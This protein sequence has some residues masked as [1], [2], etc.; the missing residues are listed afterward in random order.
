MPTLRLLAIADRAP[1]RRVRDIIS[2]TPVDVIVTLGDLELSQIRDLELITDIPKLG[3]YG[4]HC[5]GSY[6]DTVGLVN[7]HLNTTTVKGITFGGFEGSVRYKNSPYAKMY[8]QEEATALLADFPRVDVMLTH[9]P[10]YGI[11]DDQRD[12]SHTGFLGLRTYLEQKSPPYLLHG[13]TYP[14]EASLVQEYLNTRIE[15]VFG[16]RIVEITF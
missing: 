6:M 7:M 3:V 8:T 5:S 11:N 2:E 13:H 1:S 15:Y 16:E 4:N 9:C 12:L 10:P 14:T